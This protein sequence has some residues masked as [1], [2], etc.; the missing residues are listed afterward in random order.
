MEKPRNATR[1]RS[2]QWAWEDV[3]AGTPHAYQAFEFKPKS[4]HFAVIFTMDH[5]ICRH[6]GP[7]MPYFAE[8]YRHHADT[9]PD[10]PGTGTSLR[11]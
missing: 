11:G 7:I 3:T 2:L 5:A 10:F 8:I 4:R 6:F 1:D 9:L